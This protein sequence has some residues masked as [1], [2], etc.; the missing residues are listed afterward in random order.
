MKV[1]SA[2]SGGVDSAVAT[3]ILKEQGL[4]VSGAF[5]KLFSNK[6]SVESEKRAHSIAEKLNIPFHVFDF[7]KEFK[8]EIIDYFVESYRDGRTPNPCIVC[9]K[10]MKFGLFLDKA[11]ELGFDKIATGHY[12]VR[13]KKDNVFQIKKGK[14]EAKDQSYFLWQLNQGQLSD[15]LFPLGNFKKQK[16]KEVARK[17]ELFNLISGESQ[18]VCFIKETVQSFLKEKLR[19][20]PGKIIDKGGNVLGEHK[21]L[22]FYTIGQRKGIELS[23]GPFYVLNKDLE[24]NHLVVTKDKTDLIKKEIG[25]K[26]INWIAE[27]EPSLPLKCDAQIRYGAKSFQSIVIKEEN[28][29]LL[30]VNGEIKSVSPGQS[31]VFYQ[32]DQVLGGAVIYY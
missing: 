21:G 26:E 27:V 25:L 15:T 18:D 13:E 12:V 22:W 16:V 8:K 23:G 1:L 4:N 10:R 5:M 11:R 32:K 30:K 24:N 6:K 7:R 17:K 28:K 20:N 31:A 14:D 9:N 3:S 29:Y 2:I 19:N